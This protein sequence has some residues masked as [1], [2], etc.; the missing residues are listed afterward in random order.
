MGQ[1]VR[2]LARHQSVSLDEGLDQ[3]PAPE[4]FRPDGE[5]K[6][7]TVYLTPAAAAS[8]S[9]EDDLGQDKASDD[10]PPSKK[11]RNKWR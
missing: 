3:A 11:L 9:T 4:L 1:D 10:G 6:E 2:E 5:T 7:A 8:P